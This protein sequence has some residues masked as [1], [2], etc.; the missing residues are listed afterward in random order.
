MSGFAGSPGVGNPIGAV[1][2]GFIR[3]LRNALPIQALPFQLAG[4]GNK[5]TQIVLDTPAP[6]ASGTAVWFTGYTVGGPLNFQNTTFQSITSSTSVALNTVATNFYQDNQGN[7]A[8]QIAAISA[9]GQHFTLTDVATSTVSNQ[10]ATNLITAWSPVNLATPGSAQCIWWYDPQDPTCTYIRDGVGVA[11][12]VAG[13]GNK[14]NNR[15]YLNAM[16]GPATLGRGGA[17][18]F[19]RTVL[20]TQ[21]NNNTTP[22]T[23]AGTLFGS[24]LNDQCGC[25]DI[26]QLLDGS[27]VNSMVPHTIVGALT[28]APIGGQTY[29][30]FCIWQNLPCSKY[31][32]VRWNGSSGTPFDLNIAIGNGLGVGNSSVMSAG[33]YYFT[34]TVTAGGQGTFRVN[35]AQTGQATNTGADNPMFNQFFGVFVNNLPVSPIPFPNGV[36]FSALGSFQIY[37]GVLA[38]G[39]ITSAEAWV[40]RSVNF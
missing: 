30:N 37:A 33:Q 20:A 17:S 27:N 16:G 1:N 19:E 39:D 32:Q 29:A 14:L 21:Q 24:Y 18:G 23:N 3:P 28:Q 34:A 15:Q 36:P 22:W 25:N 31:E 4:F 9:T 6:A 38:A 12:V 5:I 40:T 7:F 26:I 11:P 8:F 35:G 10:S 13:I 2:S